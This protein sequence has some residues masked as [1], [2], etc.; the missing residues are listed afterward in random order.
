M[1]EHAFSIGKALKIDRF[2]LEARTIK[3][4]SQ[5]PLEY[6]D[7]VIL[8][9]ST[10]DLGS[11]LQRLK[12]L[13]LPTAHL[14]RITLVRMSVF[15]AILKGYLSRE[16]RAICLSGS[17][18]STLLDTL[19]IVNPSLEFPWL[20]KNTLTPIRR[21]ADL[22]VFQRLLEIALHF[23]KEGREGKPIGTIFVLGEAPEEHL[24]QLV[25][26]PL[27]GHSK[28][29]RNIYNSEFVESLRELSALDGGFVVNSQG[30][31]E[32]AGVY[33]AAPTEGV[34]V[35][36]GLGARHAAAAA[37]TR[38]TKSVA[39]VISESSGAVRVFCEGK[40]VL[41]LE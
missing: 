21:V 36:P 35:R 15:L 5:I 12:T 30:T 37:F 10:A 33:F 28:Q 3:D 9:S 29:A 6:R 27:K 40:S 19:L 31:V 13:Q 2:L 14:S 25:L 1:I 24:M 23:A 39:V 4:V 41:E 7:K 16:Q 22:S 26:N 11:G 20:R 8:V 32:K 18:R 38:Q 17:R 34:R